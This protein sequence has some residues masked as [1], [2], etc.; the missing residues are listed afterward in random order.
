MDKH[1]K[2]DHTASPAAI[3][4]PEQ[5]RTRKQVTASLLAEG[6][7][8]KARWKTLVAP[9]RT[10]WPKLSVEE[11]R[12]V[13]GDIHRLAGLVQLRCQLSREES[14]RQVKAFFA[15]HAATV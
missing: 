3:A 8:A 5:L 12:P 7:A 6:I 13:H 2:Q 15:Q 1:G 9:A 14:D 11:L 10:T 4:R